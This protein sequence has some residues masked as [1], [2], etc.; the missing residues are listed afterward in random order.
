MI[1]RFFELPQHQTSIRQEVIGGLT[2]FLTMAYI[3]IVNPSVLSETGMDQSALVVI[4]CLVAGLYT[5][6]MGTRLQNCL[7]LNG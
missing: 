7:L 1:S 6:L 3:I 2:T 4:T 5:I